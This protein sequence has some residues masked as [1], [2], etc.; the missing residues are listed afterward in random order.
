MKKAIFTIMVILFVA[1]DAPA[2]VFGGS[3]LG[4][5][6]YPEFSGYRPGKPYSRE[7]YMISS[8]RM[9]MENYLSEIEEYL[10]NA[11]NDI[12]RI[13]E[14]MQEAKDEADDAVNE[15]N[16]FIRSGY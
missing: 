14:A 1:S 13:S 3:N 11:R 15:F 6:G 7:S 9:E 16:R 2:F 12:K 4:I 8:Y 5:L 10:D